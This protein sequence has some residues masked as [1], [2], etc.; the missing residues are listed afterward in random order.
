MVG[1]FE[2]L[3]PW[4]GGKCCICIAVLFCLQGSGQDHKLFSLDI[5]MVA[6]DRF[7]LV[8]TSQ[9][10]GMSLAGLLCQLSIPKMLELR[11]VQEKE[12]LSIL[13]DCF[14]C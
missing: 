2:Q 11:Q 3:L 5:T 4:A 8:Q 12:Q 13:S 9:A 1:Q 6:E 14:N 7:S 10:V